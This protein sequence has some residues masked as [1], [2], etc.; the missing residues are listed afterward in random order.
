MLTFHPGDIIKAVPSRSN[1]LQNSSI[2]VDLNN[3]DI[4]TLLLLVVINLK[5]N[6]VYYCTVVGLS[7]R[8]APSIISKSLQFRFRTFWSQSKALT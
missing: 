3:S 6:L 5:K 8:P 7:N 1:W 2:P 4:F